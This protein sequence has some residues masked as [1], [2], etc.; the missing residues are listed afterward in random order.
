MKFTGIIE[1]V[2]A[3]RNRN[4]SGIRLFVKLVSHKGSTEQSVFA[5]VQGM[6]ALKVLQQ[7]DDEG[8][9]QGVWRATL[10]PC[11]HEYVG[12]QG[13]I[14]ANLMHITELELVD[15]EIDSVNTKQAPPYEGNKA[16]IADEELRFPLAFPGKSTGIMNWVKSVFA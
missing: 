15:E 3:N 4:E 16:A 6:K 14:Y 9:V 8:V 10:S 7:M 11:V 12:S 5:R 2:E 13:T 1:A